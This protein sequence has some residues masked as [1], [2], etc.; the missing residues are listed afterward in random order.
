[1]ALPRVV[2][3]STSAATPPREP[4]SPATEQR[5][6]QL[7]Y[8]HRYTDQ[9]R[10][11]VVQFITSAMTIWRFSPRSR[12]ERV[13]A[14]TRG[15]LVLVSLV[16]V[17]LDPPEREYLTPTINAVLFAYLAYS[18]TII[19]LTW[20]RP[21]VVSRIV[22]A[23][24]VI[25]LGIFS[26]MYWLTQ[27][28]TNPF[29][30]YFVFSIFC[31]ALR[32]EW[33]GTLWTALAAVTLYLAIGLYTGTHE[34]DFGLNRFIVNL[35][36]L[37]VV[38]VLL[39]YLGFHNERVRTEIAQL[40]GWPRLAAS[41]DET[42]LEG[43]LAHVGRLV[44]CPRVVLVWDEVEEPWVN[45]A[46]WT[47]SGVTRERHPPDKFHPLVAEGMEGISFICDGTDA[48]RTVAPLRQAHGPL[49]HPE[50][51]ARY[52]TGTAL[53]LPVAGE[54]VSGLLLCLGRENMTLDDLALGEVAVRE[55]GGALDQHYLGEQLRLLAV[56]EE[57]LKLARDLHDG[58]LQSLTAAR[59]QI[60]ALAAELNG[61]TR[62]RLGAIERA[63]AVEQ[64]ELRTFIA[65]LQP[66]PAMASHTALG[67]RFETLKERIE[68][69][70]G[71]R[72]WIS[73]RPDSLTLPEQLASDVHLMVQEALVNVARHASASRAEVDIVLESGSLHI[74]V[75]DDGHGFPFRGRLE[76]PEL[77]SGKGPRSL[78]ERVL[79]LGGT[80][81]VESTSS[82]SRVELAVPALV[83]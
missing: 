17:W 42:L 16:A 7:V 56:S 11:R 45:T 65:G 43:L 81:A 71:L 75:S 15:A 27:G 2:C 14:V 60:D 31:G 40:A 35:V 44:R 62:E 64:G 4:E 32:W 70:W 13:I 72:V 67:Q 58:V 61:T 36:Y 68:R 38:T 33:R 34:V 6:A 19:L 18:V 79:A 77:R 73:I 83:S 28:P 57:R 20:T 8:N 1:V 41:D 48:A 55:L 66:R 29:F 59:L 63:I 54:Q 5:R 24:H 25:D 22:T 51:A 12:S 3:L 80:I 9:P 10:I 69:Q 82:G 26:L 53:A 74:T 23:T 49:L 30:V 47:A 78:R 76:T 52:L 39:A 46:V 50:L 21:D 37:M